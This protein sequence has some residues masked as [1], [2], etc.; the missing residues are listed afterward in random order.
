MTELNT[1][2]VGTQPHIIPVSPEPNLPA[3]FTG[4]D[5]TKPFTEQRA[6]LQRRALALYTA[7]CTELAG[8]TGRVEDDVELVAYAV[9]PPEVWAPRIREALATYT[10]HPEILR[11]EVAR[12]R[13]AMEADTS[14]GMSREYF[15][16]AAFVDFYE[17]FTREGTRLTL[18]H[19]GVQAFAEFARFLHGNDA[20]NEFSR[21]SHFSFRTILSDRTPL[22]LSPEAS[23]ET[24]EYTSL[25]TPGMP[26]PI[27]SDR[28]PLLDTKQTARQGIYQG[29]EL[30]LAFQFNDRKN[31]ISYGIV[32]ITDPKIRREKGARFALVSLGLGDGH[33]A[34]RILDSDLF[35]DNEATTGGWGRV[36][37]K[38]TSLVSDGETI[39]RLDWS[40]DGII[41]SLESSANPVDVS[42]Q[43]ASETV[44]RTHAKV[45]QGRVHKRQH[46]R[47]VGMHALLHGAA[48]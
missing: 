5:T 14:K 33:K 31:P 21:D 13:T 37:R 27:P 2:D 16:N 30:R 4:P 42:I 40:D 32:G 35:Q 43:A 26:V 24:G 8:L 39:V 22:S 18:Q 15:R 20:W 29:G 17:P 45:E 10:A 47:R 11:S 44:T 34:P 6:W 9:Q 23:T 19:S 25:L 7:E 46:A 28:L 38:H 12:R 36:I 3:E 48:R 1:V 41:L